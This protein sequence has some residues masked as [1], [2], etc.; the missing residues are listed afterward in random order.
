M[1]HWSSGLPV[2]FLSQ[3]TRVHSPGGYLCETGILL[4]TCSRYIGDHNVIDHG[5]LVWGRPRPEPS[6]GPHAENV[7]I[8]LDLTQLSCPGFT[9]AAGHPSGFTS[10]GVGCWGGEPCREPAISLHFHQVSLVQWTTCLLPVTKDPDSIPRGVPL[11]NH[12]S[13]VSVI[14]LQYLWWFFAVLYIYAEKF[15]KLSLYVHLKN[16]FLE[17]LW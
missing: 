5:G 7:I 6:I 9:L 4:L 3:G 17:Y 13:P 15:P 8:P 12:D 16:S 14:L 2:C 11:W 1:S 10:D